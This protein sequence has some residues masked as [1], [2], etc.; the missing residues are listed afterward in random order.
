M[1][2]NITIE[3]AKENTSLQFECVLTTGLY[4][5]CSIERM[6]FPSSCCGYYCCSPRGAAV[7]GGRGRVE[8]SICVR[9]VQPGPGR[10]LPVVALPGMQVKSIYMH[11]TI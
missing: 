5:Q 11:A 4:K 2:L 8:R 1:R 10:V 7:G 6:L 3:R 9:Q